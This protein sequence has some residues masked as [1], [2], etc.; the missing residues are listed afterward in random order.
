[1][2]PD[3]PGSP[4]RKG[5]IQLHRAGAAFYNQTGKHPLSYRI[6][7]PKK[8][9]PQTNGCLNQDL[10]QKK[11][12]QLLKSRFWLDVNHGCRSFTLSSQIASLQAQQGHRDIWEQGSPQ[13]FSSS[14]PGT[15]RTV[16]K[17]MD[18][19]KS[20][21]GFQDEPRLWGCLGRF[22]SCFC[23]DLGST[24]LILGSSG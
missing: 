4:L 15:E 20:M 13:I 5:S 3:T 24:A 22:Q 23:R 14:S 6:T 17:L 19:W 10:N 16:S 1:M 8:S 2:S 7:P 9:Y 18:K 11:T 12:T 21:G